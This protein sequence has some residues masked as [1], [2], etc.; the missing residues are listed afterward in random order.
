MRAIVFFDLPTDSAEDRRQ[1]R[2]FRKLLIKEGFIMMQ[3]S[4][5]YKLVLNE[6]SYR[7]E[8]ERLRKKRPAKGLVQV[9]R[10]TE[11][12]FTDMIYLAGDAQVAEEV[13]SLD[14]L[15]II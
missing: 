2:Q 11:K 5:Y 4:V 14:S 6:Q 8:I 13:T 12:Q 3:E 7:A 9:L 1:Y 15:V 10:I